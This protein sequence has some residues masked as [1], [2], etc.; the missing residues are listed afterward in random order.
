MRRLSLF[1]SF[2]L[3]PIVT[4]FAQD[5]PY[6]LK[7]DYTVANNQLVI[8]VTLT[9]PDQVKVYAEAANFFEVQESVSQNLGPIEVKLPDLKIYDDPFT[10]NQVRVFTAPTS[11]FKI[12]KPITNADQPWAYQFAVQT[13]GCTAD[14]C[15]PPQLDEFQFGQ[16]SSGS[17]QTPKTEEVLLD[18]DLTD[19]TLALLDQYQFVNTATG[20][21]NAEEFTAFLENEGSADDDLFK[22]QN[23]LA[24]IFIILGGGLLLNLTPCILPMIPI[25]L[26]IIGAGRKSKSKMDGFLKGLYYGLGIALAYGILGLV[27]IFSGAQFGSL[28]SQPWFNFALAIIFIVLG[29]AMM[30]VIYIDLSRF[31]KGGPSDKARS[32]RFIGIFSLGAVSALLAGACVAPVVIAVLLH[33]ATLYSEGAYYALLLPFLLGVGMALPWPLAGA[34]LGVLPKPGNWMT[35]VKYLFVLFIFVF[36]AS[37]AWT[38]YKLLNLSSGNQSAYSASAEVEKL[39]AALA[40]GLKEDRRVIVDFWATWCGSCMK[41]KRTTLKDPVV[42]EKL[43]KELFIEFQAEQITEVPVKTITDAM[44]VKGLPTFIILEPKSE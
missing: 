38:G 34:G 43:E 19:R 27:S 24:V 37:Y 21:M 8:D 23:W 12:I 15:F 30:D 39:N 9:I 14:T 42:K 40:R 4:L 16:A 1:L 29:L 28:N 20:E 13:Q 36:A 18:S 17:E 2:L 41:M 33:S 7:A 11:S 3:L 25:N 31:K 44:Q 26:A 22:G 6:T 5:K 35:K 10:G 32:G